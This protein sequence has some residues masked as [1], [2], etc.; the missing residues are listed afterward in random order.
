MIHGQPQRCEG[1]QLA[2]PVSFGNTSAITAAKYIN[3]KGFM[4]PLPERFKSI[5]DPSLPIVAAD[6]FSP[7][8]KNRYPTSTLRVQSQAKCPGR[9]DTIAYIEA[10]E[11]AKGM[12]AAYFEHVA[13]DMGERHLGA[14]V[15]SKFA[16]PKMGPYGNYVLQ[17]PRLD[18]AL[19]RGV[20]ALPFISTHS[21]A[22][23]RA[24]PDHL[25]VRYGTG[26]QSA[27]GA[28][29]VDEGVIFLLIDLVRRFAGPR[30]YP[31]WIEL[32]CPRPT[33][34]AEVE[35]LF[36]TN[37]VFG[38]E[39][40]AIAIDNS[41]LLTPNTRKAS[42]ASTMVRD[43]IRRLS[44]A[45]PPRTFAGL[46]SDTMTTCLSGGD[47]SIESVSARI[48]LGT[49]TLQRK[50]RRE[51]FSFRDI[52]SRVLNTRA[53]ALLRE[54]ELSVADI[55]TELGFDEV[56][57]FRRAFQGWTDLTPTKFKQRLQKLPMG[58]ES[59]I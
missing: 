47:A 10:S 16:Y 56:N 45:R 54:T 21:W 42:I 52:R 27:V 46:V 55:A 12:L 40:P 13:R 35:A 25:V 33:N 53:Q 34:V 38:A 14:I 48:G 29:Q 19:R 28:W 58:A 23:L 57:S 15:G 50:L 22:E 18:L 5:S 39:L 26:V 32:T 24:E 9:T 2:I 36:G 7:P 3:T 44:A 49:R 6:L 17:A 43:D 1:N 51:G 11:C 30:W 4:H 59:P 41:I 31:D 20:R 37:I 8:H